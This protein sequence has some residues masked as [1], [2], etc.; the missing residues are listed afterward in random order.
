MKQL[1]RFLCVLLTCCMVAAMTLD[2]V[3]AATVKSGSCGK[4]LTWTLT[5]K[6]ELSI[7]GTGVM[8]FGGSESSVPWHNQRERVRTIS[9]DPRITVIAELAFSNCHNLTRVVIPEGITTIGDAAFENCSNLTDVS[10]PNSVT[11]IDTAVFEGTP[12][13]K[14]LGDLAIVNEMLLRY[15]GTDA[16]VTIPNNITKI[17]GGAFYNC[18]NLTSVNIPESIIE[19]G[20]SAFQGCSNL[21]NI[22]IPQGI[23][24]IDAFTFRQCTNLVRI[25]IPDSVSKIY[26]EAFSGCSKLTSINIPDSVEL[27][28]AGAFANCGKLGDIYYSGSESQWNKIEVYPP[29]GALSSALIHYNSSESDNVDTDWQSHRYK[30]FDSVASKWEEAENYCKSLGGHL[31]TISCQ[32]EN[33]FIYQLMIDAGYRSAYFGLTDSG[34]EGNWK[35]VT[36]EPVLY[37]NWHLG[38][39]NSENGNEDYAMFY[40]KYSDGTW[41][42][43]DFGGHTVNGGTAFICEWDNGEIVSDGDFRVTANSASTC[44]AKGSLTEMYIGYY[45]EDSLDLSTHEYIYTL[46]DS[47]ILDIKPGRWSD[48]D[49]QHFEIIAKETGNCILTITHPQSGKSNSIKFRVVEGGTGYSFNKVPEMTIE[50]GKTTNFYDHTYSSK[51]F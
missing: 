16:N 5:D 6:G 36:K 32:E 20:N 14:S 8:Y 51:F 40:Y 43:G 47:N 4:N 48:E 46:S 42:D 30:V 10:I 38:E 18:A 41:N 24:T 25:H 9:L 21:T 35:W 27:I 34:N 2:V 17:C 1:K 29:K 13:L 12:W 44:L 31:A 45:E 7:V 3:D 33:D 15:Q 26:T 22:S 37:T 49:G 19:I 50:Q 39:P 11:N 28:G 23:T